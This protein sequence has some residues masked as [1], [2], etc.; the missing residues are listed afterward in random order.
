MVHYIF[1]SILHVG[2]DADIGNASVLAQSRISKVK[3]GLSDAESFARQ[4]ND[5]DFDFLIG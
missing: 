4:G 3:K 2:P 1:P 5:F